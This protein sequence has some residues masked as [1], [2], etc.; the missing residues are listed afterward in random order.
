MFNNVW[1]PPLQSG[2][3]A[4]RKWDELVMIRSE[5]EDLRQIA[6]FEK[7]LFRRYR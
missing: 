3:K 7:N 2:V 6:F 4:I 1:I 5:V